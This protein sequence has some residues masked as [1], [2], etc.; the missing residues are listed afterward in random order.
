MVGS[1]DVERLSKELMT[2][3]R[4]AVEKIGWV[5]FEDVERLNHRPTHRG[6]G[7][8]Q[9][10]EVSVAASQGCEFANMK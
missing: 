7:N 5:L 10:F 8:G 6:I 4:I 2:L 1:G 3:D 9:H